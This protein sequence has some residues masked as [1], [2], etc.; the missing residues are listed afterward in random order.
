MNM[1]VVAEQTTVPSHVATINPLWLSAGCMGYALPKVTSHLAAD[2]K[3]W[4]P[5]IAQSIGQDIT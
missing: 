4:L 1:H 3:R 5:W 2:V